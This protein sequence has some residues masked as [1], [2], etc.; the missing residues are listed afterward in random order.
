MSKSFHLTFR[1]DSWDLGE[2]LKGLDHRIVVYHDVAG[3]SIAVF[4]LEEFPHLSLRFLQEA[5]P[6]WRFVRLAKWNR[7]FTLRIA[8]NGAPRRAAAPPPR[9]TINAQ[10]AAPGP[11]TLSS[12][13]ACALL[14]YTLYHDTL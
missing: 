9:H 10:I 12:A 8:N 13:W 5:A 6:P 7:S 2:A 4:L 1:K 3:A 14:H 11:Q